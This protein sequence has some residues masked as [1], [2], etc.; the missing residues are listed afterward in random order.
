[1]VR[2]H[3]QAITHRRQRHPLRCLLR[4]WHGRL[5]HRCAIRSKPDNGSVP[6]THLRRCPRARSKQLHVEPIAQRS[7][8]CRHQ[9]LCQRYTHRLRHSSTASQLLRHEATRAGKS[10]Q[11]LQNPPNHCTPHRGCL[12][13]PHPRSRAASQAARTRTIRRTRYETCGPHP[14]RRP[15]QARCP[16]GRYGGQAA[17][18]GGRGAGARRGRG[19]ELRTRPVR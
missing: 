5:L 6:Q 16:E 12:A 19:L 13:C 3:P 11:K 4:G 1:M 7:D 8:H 9:L 17:P 14:S 10:K 15:C 2:G 18:I